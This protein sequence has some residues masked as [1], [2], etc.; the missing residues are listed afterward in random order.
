MSRSKLRDFCT[1]GELV[2]MYDR[3]YDHTRWPEHCLRVQHTAA[4]LS[5]MFPAS[6]ADLS[7]GDGAVARAAAGPGCLQYMG[8]LVPGW[9]FT[10]PIE[11]TI[12]LIPPVDVFV[13]SETLE[14]VE[15]P[16]ALLAAIRAKASRLLLT[17]PSGEWLPR[18]PE[19]YW[20][21]EPADVDLMLD[22]AGWK[23]R[24]CQ[25]YVPPVPEP[26]YHYQVWECS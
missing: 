7:C 22:A 26:Y 10:G 18:N 1:P 19:H 16:D 8:D 12:S 14:H 23:Q 13:C 17:T 6:V 25:L 21:W 20:G 2:Q 9:Q 5:R 24:D 11:Q 4:V 15:D 3:P